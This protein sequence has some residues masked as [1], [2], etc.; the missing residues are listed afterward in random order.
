[1]SLLLG[2]LRAVA[3]LARRVGAGVAGAVGTGIAGGLGGGGARGLVV[4][5]RSKGRR[6]SA[7]GQPTRILVGNRVVNLRKRRRGISGT[8][9]RGFTKVVGLLR[10]VGMRPAGLGGR[11]RG[12]RGHARRR[13]RLRGDPDVMPPEFE[14]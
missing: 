5:T 6:A 4:L 3:P 12:L 10:K 2:Q 8:E 11:G 1:M 9:L 7:G 14:D 13:G